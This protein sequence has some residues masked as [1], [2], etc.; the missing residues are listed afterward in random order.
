MHEDRFRNFPFFS[1]VHLIY[2][3][4]GDNK[5]LGRIRQMIDLR[6]FTYFIAKKRTGT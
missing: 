4:L 6:H 5:F 1:L 2:R 3:F